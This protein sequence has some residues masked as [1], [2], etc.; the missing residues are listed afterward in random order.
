MHGKQQKTDVYL[1]IFL[2]AM[3]FILPTMMMYVCRNL[4]KPFYLP[5]SSVQSSVLK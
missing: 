1:L 4:V 5:S 2:S 3:L